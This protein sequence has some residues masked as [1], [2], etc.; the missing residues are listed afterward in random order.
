VRW[1]DWIRP[2]SHGPDAA[3][4]SEQRAEAE[5]LSLERGDIDRLDT[6]FAP[7]PWLEDAGRSSWLFVGAF[8]LLGGAI[9]LLAETFAIV[10]PVV[11]G[12]VI[13]TVAIPLVSSMHRRGLPRAAG[14]GIVLL[15]IV[16]LG[17]A[18]LVLVL[19][20]VRDQSSEISAA[21][22]SGAAKAQGWL[23]SLGVNQGSAEHVNSNVSSALPAAL[24]TLKD[25][26]V[27]G[28]RGLTSIAISVS[29]LFLALFFLL[30]DGPSMR[31]VI[32]RHLGVPE[33]V[34]RTITG[35]V[36]RSLRGYFKGVTIVAA[37]NGVVIGLSAWALGIPLPATI[38]V[39]NFV[40]AYIP[41][42]GAFVGGA[43]AVVL[44]LGAK[45]TTV[46]IV[47][48]VIVILANGLL[49]NLVQPFAMGS[50]LDLHPLVVLIV[51]IAA[52]C[53]FGTL[54]LILAAPLVSA[55]VHIKRELDRAR[56]AAAVEPPPPPAAAA[57]AEA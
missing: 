8:A 9:W 11:V 29:F 44:A 43:F 53:L 6:V 45:G 30:K 20:G 5:R 7:P 2:G 49:Q 38:G 18:V 4:T 22:S 15:G 16:A 47:M 17:V 26:I 1:L 24:K 51:T 14:A 21:A 55:A 39:V 40:L 52:G 25:G 34:A 32:D 3:P 56:T 23:E 41:Y 12:T 13:A 28:I 31:N 57:P 10:G 19:A 50:A 33:P 42:I 37:F 48:L 27:S 36:I 46:A 35:G 54:G